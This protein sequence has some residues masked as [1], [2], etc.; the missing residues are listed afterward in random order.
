MLEDPVK[1]RDYRDKLITNIKSVPQLSQ[2]TLMAND[3]QKS[4]IEAIADRSDPTELRKILANYFERKKY[5]LQHKKYK[6]LS[7]WA[8][9]AIKTRNIE[10]IA[11]QATFRFSKLQ[12]EIDNSIKRAQRLSVDDDYKLGL[13]PD[14]RPTST[15][16]NNEAV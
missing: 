12:Q 2:P 14:N 16:K 4:R 5:G 3:L 11:Q 7:R 13:D 6:L 10:K 8:H 15:A 1:Q 9:H